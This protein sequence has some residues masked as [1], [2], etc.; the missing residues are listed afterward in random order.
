MDLKQLNLNMY[1]IETMYHTKGNFSL[2]C[3]ETN[4]LVS[5]KKFCQS[6]N[7]VCRTLKY[8]YAG[9]HLKYQNGSMNYLTLL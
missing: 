6:R 9:L 7:N 1:L 3:I 5:R 4:V 2:K 8:Y